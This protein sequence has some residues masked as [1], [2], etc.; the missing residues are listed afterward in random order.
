VL[1]QAM[2]RLASP[3]VVVTAEPS[4][5]PP[6]G[7]TIGSFTSVA[8]EPPLA[9]FNVTRGTRLHATLAAADQFAVHLLAFDQ[10]AMAA[11]FAD[12]ELDSDSQFAA[13][14][15]SRAGA[16]AP[17]VLE[18]TLAVLCCR[19]ERSFEAGDHTVFVGRVVDVLPGRDAPPLIYHRQTYRTVEGVGVA[20][21]RFDD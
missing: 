20:G 3:V 15:H 16:G 8:L 14:R 17:P 12:P 4:G 5:R 19:V 13:Y 7:A 21:P 10:A 11:H 9:S 6:R 18:D 2:R 1:R